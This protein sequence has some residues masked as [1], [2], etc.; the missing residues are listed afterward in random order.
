MKLMKSCLLCFSVCCFINR[1]LIV[2]QALCFCILSAKLGCFIYL[3]SFFAGE[4]DSLSAGVM[5]DHKRPERL[6]LWKITNTSVPSLIKDV[7]STLNHC[8]N[9]VKLTL[10]LFSC[11]SPPLFFSSGNGNSVKYWLNGFMWGELFMRVIFVWPLRP[12]SGPGIFSISTFTQIPHS[13]SSWRNSKEH[14]L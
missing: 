14:A 9:Q 4:S 6:S 8:H 3:W 11:P 5:S 1:H 10:L 7:K 12:P 2:L 13:L